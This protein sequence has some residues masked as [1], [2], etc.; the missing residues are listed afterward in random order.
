MATKTTKKTKPKSPPLQRPLPPGLSLSSRFAPDTLRLLFSQLFQPVELAQ[1]LPQKGRGFYQRLFS[2]LIV[3]WYFCFLRLGE[4]RVLQDVISDVHNGGAD[5]LTPRAK[6]LSQRLKSWATTSFSKARQRFPL[7]ALEQALPA[8]AQKIRAW[9]Q[10]L[11]WR[12][13]NVCLLDGST[14]RLRPLGNIPKQFPP[15]KNRR[16]DRQYWCLVRVVVGFC[17]HSAVVVGSAVGAVMVSEQTLACQIIAAALPQSLFVGDRNFGIFR[18]AQVVRQA[19]AQGLFRL[20][21]VRACKLAGVPLVPGLD[22]AVAWQHSRHDQLEP[23]ADPSPVK[24]RLIVM[25]LHRKGFRS[26]M[27]YLFTTLEDAQQYPTAELVE[28]Y[29]WRWHVELNLRYLKSEMALNALHCKSADMARKEW[30]AG[31]LAYNLIRAAMLAAALQA[32]RS[33]LE[34]SFSSAQSL[35]R[36]WIVKQALSPAAAVH[37]WEVL[38]QGIAHTRLPSRRK[39]RLAEPRRK[40]QITDAFPPLWGDR[41]TARQQLLEEQMKR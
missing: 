17:L 3:L 2:P 6:P 25:Q 36:C 31:L 30:L 8:Q 12:G 38:L 7:A 40:R 9:A 4:A 35:V 14:L 5:H 32:G 41:Q 29:G 37:A 33:V 23:G 39:A 18:L 28:L 15:H 10:N 20:T 27:L 22:L 16:A 19:K 21:H 13:W 34:F 26:F 1:W 24:G 11:N